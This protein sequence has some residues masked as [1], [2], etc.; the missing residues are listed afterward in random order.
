MSLAGGGSV[1][2]YILRPVPEAPSSG[3]GAVWDKSGA[4]WPFGAILAWHRSQLDETACSMDGPLGFLR[5][6][7]GT[8]AT[9]GPGSSRIVKFQ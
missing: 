6:G 2:R 4:F 5:F 1:R 9:Y 3:N 7:E 8:L